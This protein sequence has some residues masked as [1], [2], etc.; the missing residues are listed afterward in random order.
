MLACVTVVFLQAYP[1]H[2]IEHVNPAV[3]FAGDERITLQ[4]RLPW[5]THFLPLLSI[6]PVQYWWD[7]S[8]AWLRI[9]SLCS[10]SKFSYSCWLHD[11]RVVVFFCL[12]SLLVVFSLWWT[13]H[14]GIRRRTESGQCSHF[15]LKYYCALMKK[16]TLPG[17]CTERIVV[18]SVVCGNS[19]WKFH[20][21]LGYFIASHLFISRI[22]ELNLDLCLTCTF[23]Q[24]IWALV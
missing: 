22:N 13:A 6:L 2:V 18:V 5:F 7:K 23:L 14:E 3:F 10:I 8:T 20:L 11:L 9:F 16:K 17:H 15:P 19:K 21:K 12:A 1:A 24:R 4:V